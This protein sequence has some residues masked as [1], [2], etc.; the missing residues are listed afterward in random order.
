MMVGNRHALVQRFAQADYG[1][2]ADRIA[3]LKLPTLIVYFGRVAI[4]IA[5]AR[6]D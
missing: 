3:E 6:F 2:N 5:Q 1:A 4:D